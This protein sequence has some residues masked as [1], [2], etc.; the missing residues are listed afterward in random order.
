[1]KE[2]VFILV[3]M[4]L[5]I[6]VRSIN[7]PSHLNFSSEQASFS[8]RSLEIWENKE[9]T[10]LGPS[11]S[12]KA[13]GREIFQSS[14]TYY[15]MIPFLILGGQD[16]ILS[17]YLLV[18]FGS[19]MLYFLYSG[20]KKL[21]GTEAAVLLTG[22][23]AFL[24]FY[25]DYSRFFWNPNFQFL[26]SP[27]LIYLLGSYK[28]TKKIIYCFLA[29]LFSG[30]LLLFH[31]QFVVVIA[32]VLVYLRLTHRQPHI[33]ILGATAGFMPMIVFELHNNFYNIRTAIMLLGGE[34]NGHKL[35]PHY[36]L[37]VSLFAAVLFSTFIKKASMQ[38]IAFIVLLLLFWS[39]VKYS[40][41]PS[42]GFGMAYSWY[43]NSEKQAYEIIKNEKLERY[44]VVNLIYDTQ[45]NVQMYLHIVDNKAFSRDYL[46]NDYLYII[47]TDSGIH[48]THAYEVT[49]FYPSTQVKM[50]NIGNNYSLYLYKR[51]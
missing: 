39:M 31:Y 25:I 6:L 9:A 22:L 4:L 49:S 15:T 29:G 44:S 24:P 26:L 35:V 33:F 41:M 34:S 10:L 46:E 23:F 40:Q 16:P 43:F 13:G 37:S 30:L 28:K 8:I 21:T 3:M 1:M 50:W 48:E 5:Y 42:N 20:T 51:T 17:S 47:S 14:I 19:F 38:K 12:F 32:A 45:A 11:I 27:L 36:F 18:L 2:K 7:F